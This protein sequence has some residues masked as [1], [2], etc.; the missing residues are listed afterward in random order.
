[1]ESLTDQVYDEAK[2]LIDEVEAMGGMAKAIVAGVPKL[3]I[4]EC[5]AKRQ[6]M[7]DDGKET[8][9]GSSSLSPLSALTLSPSLSSRRRSEQIQVGERRVDPSLADRQRTSEETTDPE[10][11]TGQET[12]QRKPGER[13][14]ARPSSSFIFP[15]SECR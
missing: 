4:E 2:R 3:K 11:R 14:I 8:I 15:L 7:I 1:M 5:A 13:E 10:D 9:V 6:A 12:T